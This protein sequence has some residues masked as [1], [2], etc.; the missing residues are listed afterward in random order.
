MWHFEFYLHFIRANP[1]P[2]YE[3][4]ISANQF[5]SPEIL[6]CT[7]PIHSFPSPVNST[8]NASSFWS[9]KTT[10]IGVPELFEN[11]NEVALIWRF[12]MWFLSQ[13]SICEAHF[14]RNFSGIEFPIS[15]SDAVALANVSTK[16]REMFVED[17]HIFT[18]HNSSIIMILTR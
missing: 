11:S 6:K 12:C 16:I 15:S 3:F 2:A 18:S 13:F 7:K 9:F 4:L 5:P 8:I 10:E 17:S 1:F 14:P